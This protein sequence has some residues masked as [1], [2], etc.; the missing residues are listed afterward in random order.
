M[1]QV[2]VNQKLPFLL[3]FV[4]L[5]PLFSKAQVDSAFAFPDQAISSIYKKYNALNERMDR[6]LAKTLSR[7]AKQER[8]LQKKLLAKDSAA[9]ALFAT[10]QQQYQH[11]QQ[12]LQN[13]LKGKKIANYIP[14]LDSLQTAS[15]FLEQ[16]KLLSNNKLGEV[17]QLNDDLQKLEGNF[18][19]AE[20]IEAFLKQRKELLSTYKTLQAG[21]SQPMTL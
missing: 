17:K 18:Y 3:L 1:K 21:H 16:S 10:S 11:L 7:F 13:P 5:M 19:S 6:Q 20:Q 9:A 4:L 15:K 14:G 8:K 2:P 12:Q